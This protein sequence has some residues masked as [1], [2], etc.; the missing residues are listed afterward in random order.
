[1]I[2]ERAYPT[3]SRRFFVCR[4]VLTQLSSICAGHAAALHAA[5]AINAAAGAASFDATRATT[6]LHATLV[7]AAAHP[8]AADPSLLSQ[9][10]VLHKHMPEVRYRSGLFGV[11]VR[12]WSRGWSRCG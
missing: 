6:C 3:C 9:L 1:M 7:V 5:T 10:E 4:E 12:M 11:W 8:D 2:S